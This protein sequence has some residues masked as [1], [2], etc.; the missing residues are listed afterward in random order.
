MKLDL[1]LK[2]NGGVGKTLYCISVTEFNSVSN[3]YWLGDNP[4]DVM[5]QFFEG[6]GW[7]E[8]YVM[9]EYCNVGWVFDEDWDEDEYDGGGVDRIEI[10]E[11]GVL[12]D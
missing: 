8:R 6:C 1:T 4:T 7:V 9:E 12:V 2:I 10:D 5:K 3:E 11:I